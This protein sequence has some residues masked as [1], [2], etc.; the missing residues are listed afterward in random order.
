MICSF[1]T[2]CLLYT[3]FLD[4]GC[5]INGILT[6]IGKWSGTDGRV[7]TQAIRTAETHIENLGCQIELIKTISRAVWK[8]IKFGNTKIY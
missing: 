4:D 7:G 8:V 3:R 6:E 2:T 1:S 5:R